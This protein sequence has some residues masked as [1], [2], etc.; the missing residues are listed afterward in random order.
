MKTIAVIFMTLCWT[1]TVDSRPVSYP[2]GWTLMQ[3]NEINRHSLHV[4]YSPT[5]RSSLG[6]KGEYWKDEK[7]KLQTLQYNRLIKRWNKPQEQANLYWKSGLGIT[8]RN[9]VAS[10]SSQLSYFTGLAADW[11]TRRY[12]ISYENQYY[13]LNA[14]GSYFSQK[15]RVGIAPY[16]G[17]YGDLHTWLMLQVN[18]H[19]Q[20]K[21]NFSLTPLVRFFKG[22]VLFE[23]GY[24]NR[25]EFLINIIVR[26]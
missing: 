17:D 16:I 11:E 4:H 26:L 10:H 5:A 13:D 24:S 2:G 22:P 6:Y 23:A 14:Y 8:E 1:L 12:F 20:S 9:Q 21:H 15:A 25:D 3:I 19:P 7:F 18:H